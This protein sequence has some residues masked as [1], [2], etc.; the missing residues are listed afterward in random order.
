MTNRE[1]Q[2]LQLIK[3]DPFIQQQQIATLL[4]ISRSSVAV[5]IMNMTKKGLIRGKGYIVD[6]KRYV[7]VIGGTNID[8]VGQPQSELIPR[9]SNPGRVSHSPGGVGRNIAENLARLGTDV[10]LISVVGDDTYG[11]LVLS[12]TR[13]AGVDTRTVNILE[14]QTTSTYLS[15]LDHDGD[16]LAAVS[17]MSILDKLDV[18]IIG[19]HAEMIRHAESIIVDTNLSESVLAYIFSNFGDQAIYLDTV[20]ATKAMKARPYLAHIHTL[21]PNLIEAQM[22]SGLPIESKSDI[23][24]VADWFIAQG[25]KR[26]FLSM[27]A[28]G[29]LFRTLR[30][31]RL[32][33][34]PST[35]IINANGAGDAFLA[36]L[37]H[38]QV[39]GMHEDTA[40]DFAINCSGLA[41]EHINTINPDITELLVQQRMEGEK[42]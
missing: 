14:G 22:I 18:S 42:C 41:M 26:L 33:Q 34:A 7:V 28:D 6:Q 23:N 24:K 38:A 15:L 4:N 40:G 8:V 17:D 19:R 3:D 9:D 13:R 36:G 25:V 32:I 30:H 37:A 10:K 35:T 11:N 5:H 39:N 12:E 27:G 20:S 16:M 29:I 2:I 1:D 21:K 31:E